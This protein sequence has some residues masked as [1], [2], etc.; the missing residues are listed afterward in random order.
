MKRKRY[1]EP[2]IVFALQQTARDRRANVPELVE[3]M[4]GIAGCRRTTEYGAAPCCLGEQ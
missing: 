2:Q 1:T 3:E 4:E